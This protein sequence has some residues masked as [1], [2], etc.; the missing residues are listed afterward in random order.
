M[1]LTGM[2]AFNLAF[3]V[4]GHVL[5]PLQTTMRRDGETNHSK[6]TQAFH[7]PLNRP[8]GTA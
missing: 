2:K 7:R 3:N 8:Q 1:S 5:M 4:R 6:T